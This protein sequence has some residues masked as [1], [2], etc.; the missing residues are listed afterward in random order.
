VAATWRAVG[1]SSFMF[2]RFT[3]PAG[4]PVRTHFALRDL[5]LTDEDDEN[6]YAHIAVH[7]VDGD[8]PLAGGGAASGRPPRLTDRAH[9]GEPTPG[10]RAHLRGHL[11]GRP[12]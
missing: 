9:K 11:F 1:A 5:A 8:G 12:G 2:E 10:A 3:D 7:D 6:A 4:S